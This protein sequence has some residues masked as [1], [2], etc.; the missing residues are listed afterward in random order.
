MADETY[1]QQTEQLLPEYQE[2]FLKSLLFSAFDPYGGYVTDAEGNFLREARQGDELAEGE[3]FVSQP[4][5]LATT[6]PLTNVPAPTLAKFGY[7]DPE[8]GE[9]TYS[10]FT[11][12]QTEALRL[13]IG[14][15]GSYQ[16]MFDAA[17]GTF[18]QGLGA[19]GEAVDMARLGGAALAGTAAEYDPQSYRDYYDPFVEQVIDETQRDISDMQQKE[20][21]RVRAGAVGSGAFGGS[22][23]AV[24]EQELARNAAREQARVGAQ[25]RS[26]AYGQAQEQAQGAFESAQRRGQNAA[27]IYGSLGQGLG[28]LGSGMF[29]AGTT[30]MAAGEA[31]QAAGARDVNALFNLGT[32]EQQQAQAELDTQRMGAM[33]AAYEPYQRLGFLS[34]IFRGVP[35]LSGSMTA[36]LAPTKD[37]T[38]TFLG[39]SMGLDSLQQGGYGGVLG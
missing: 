27:Q 1:L 37:P 31:T 24:A 35:S 17:S 9:V 32:L 38:Q 25:L 30:M 5:G 21:A 19:Y 15:I 23:G 16:P 33:E 11:P 14:Q 29:G 2:A 12:A 13:G 22:R 26:Q 10:G 28:S 8:T 6:S 3:Q 39:Y 7:K 20:L 36:G 4:T 34:D 18:S